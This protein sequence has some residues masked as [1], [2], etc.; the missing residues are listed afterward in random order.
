MVLANIP[1]FWGFGTALFSCTHRDEGR[2]V[3]EV[4]GWCS[5]QDRIHAD[6]LL[7]K[8]RL[9]DNNVAV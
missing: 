9:Y 7:L 6:L 1:P 2:E 3:R 5:D 4:V 8:Y